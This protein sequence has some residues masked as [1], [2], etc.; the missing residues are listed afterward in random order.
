MDNFEIALLGV[1]VGILLFG[2]FWVES[3]FGRQEEEVYKLI[4]QFEHLPTQ[5]RIQAMEQYINDEREK[6]ERE[7]G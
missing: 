4:D 7:C 3:A 6:F 2:I 1:A 5:T